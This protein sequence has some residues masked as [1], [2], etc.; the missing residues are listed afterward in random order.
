LSFIKRNNLSTE[1]FEFKDDHATQW[2]SSLEKGMKIRDEVMK[3]E[4]KGLGGGEGG[5]DSGVYSEEGMW[6]IGAE[7]AELVL[8]KDWDEGYEN[9]DVTPG[10]H[11]G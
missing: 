1:E 11:E 3:A 2:I 5:W 10:L 4:G 6:R 8:E 7:L 9:G